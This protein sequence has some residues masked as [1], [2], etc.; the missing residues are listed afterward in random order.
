MVFLR[1]G[2]S[3][4]NE[5]AHHITSRGYK[6]PNVSLSASVITFH[7]R[8]LS[9][10]TSLADLL[11]VTQRGRVVWALDLRFLGLL[12]LFAVFVSFR[13]SGMPEN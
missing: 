12:R 3:I 9:P 1:L 2:D 4:A 11:K 10:A 5:K 7:T 8:N 13:L 6:F